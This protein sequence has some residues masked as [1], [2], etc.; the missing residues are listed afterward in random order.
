MFK[1][2]KQL[3]KFMNNF[4]SHQSIRNSSIDLSCRLKGRKAIVTASTE[5]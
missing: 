3:T 4:I 5:G 1:T 2:S